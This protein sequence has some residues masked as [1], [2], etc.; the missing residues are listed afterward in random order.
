[1]INVISSLYIFVMCVTKINSTKLDMI[2]DIN[3]NT[4]EIITIGIG[5]LGTI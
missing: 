1:M 3:L 5:I 2:F 4:A